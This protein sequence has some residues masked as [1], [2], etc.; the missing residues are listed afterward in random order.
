[1]AAGAVQRSHRCSPWTYR[2]GP[3]TGQA[4]PAARTWS[5]LRSQAA[6][7]DAAGKARSLSDKRRPGPLAEETLQDRV[8]GDY[9]ASIG[10]VFRHVRFGSPKTADSG[11]K[12]EG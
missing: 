3:A 6:K 7:K 1:M 4:A 11:E 12:R 5:T 10:A 2:L 9:G 8:L